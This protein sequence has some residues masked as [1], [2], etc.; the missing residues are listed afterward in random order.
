MVL[1]KTQVKIAMRKHRQVVL[2]FIK[3]ARLNNI[4]NLYI[5]DYKLAESLRIKHCRSGLVQA[6]GE[7]RNVLVFGFDELENVVSVTNLGKAIQF[8]G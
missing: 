2:S 1:T 3:T 6:E 7:K 4:Q 8:I 5:S